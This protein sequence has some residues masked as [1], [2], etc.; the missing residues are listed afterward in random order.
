MSG[1][2]HGPIAAVMKHV[3]AELIEVDS[4]DSRGNRAGAVTGATGDGVLQTASARLEAASHVAPAG[5]HHVLNLHVRGYAISSYVKMALQLAC[6]YAF[7]CR[8]AFRHIAE[9]HCHM[10]AVTS[11]MCAVHNAGGA[12][13]LGEDN[14]GLAGLPL[15][16]SPLAQHA[17]KALVKARQPPGACFADH[18]HAACMAQSYCKHVLCVGAAPCSKCM[19]P[20]VSWLEVQYSTNVQH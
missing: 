19:L 16:S 20:G 17:P 11:V 5:K 14:A 3:V 6:T 10:R 18:V 15:G 7:A 8:S 4:D 12:D 1:L 2:A 9:L 13:A